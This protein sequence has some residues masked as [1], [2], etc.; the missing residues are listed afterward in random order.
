VLT[1]V[2]PDN[3]SVFKTG[4]VGDIRRDR[5]LLAELESA[6]LPDIQTQP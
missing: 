3:A 6:E 5:Y 1:A 2:E 4:E